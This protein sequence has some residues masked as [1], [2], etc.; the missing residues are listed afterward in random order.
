MKKE[1]ES[2]AGLVIKKFQSLTDFKF[3]FNAQSVKWV[4]GFLNRIRRNEGFD[5]NQ[6]Q[7]LVNTIGSFLGQCIVTCYGGEW[8]DKD[9]GP[10]IRFNEENWAFP[11]AKVEKH[12]SN[13]EGDSIYSYFTVIPAVF[14]GK[15]G[16]PE[17]KSRRKKK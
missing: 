12:L 2:N 3:G 6:K 14:K 13:G 16:N 10:G 11:F 8:G 15:I 1:I 9:G 5:D 4:D 17:E 7:G